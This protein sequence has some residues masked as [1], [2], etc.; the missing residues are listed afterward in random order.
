M[1]KVYSNPE[2]YVCT[3]ETEMM[4]LTVQS[5]SEGNENIYFDWN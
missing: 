5:S 1:K 3:T 2:L 4:T